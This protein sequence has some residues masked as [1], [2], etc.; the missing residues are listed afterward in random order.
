V[1]GK[2]DRPLYIRAYY[3]CYDPLSYPLF[4]PRGETGWNHWMPYVDPTDGR[5]QHLAYNSSQQQ[6]QAFDLTIGMIFI[7]N[8]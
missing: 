3:G 6:K 4:F 5:T 1:H 7:T 8:S 2:G